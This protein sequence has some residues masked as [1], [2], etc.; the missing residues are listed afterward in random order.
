M[1]H[2][3]N[4]AVW[5]YDTLHIPWG[6]MIIKIKPS[7]YF[8]RNNII[9]STNNLPSPIIF[10]TPTR[11]Q[12]RLA[13][14]YLLKL[15]SIRILMLAGYLLVNL[16]QDKFLEFMAYFQIHP[17]TK[18]PSVIFLQSWELCLD[19]MLS[20]YLDEENIL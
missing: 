9:C 11:F 12:P 18:L 16:L 17:R 7:V 19:P 20:W 3:F 2:W 6:N 8:W 1:F 4:E 10:P 14:F 15:F 13:S 5:Y